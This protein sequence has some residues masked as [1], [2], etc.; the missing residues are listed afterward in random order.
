MSLLTMNEAETCR[1]LVRPKLEVVGW[2]AVG[3]RHYR[4]QIPITAG[5]IVVTGGKPKRLKKKIPDFLLYF[6]RDILLAVVEAKSDNRPATDGLQQAKDYAETL[7]LK[8]AYSTNGKEIIEYDYFTHTE[9]VVPAFPSPTEVWQRYLIGM[10][11][12]GAVRDALLV[13][14]FYQPNK[15]PR[16][17][18]RIAIERA[19]RAIVGGQKRCLLTLATG[20]GKT[21]VAF[22]ICWKLW[23]ARW[24]ANADPVR[25][26]RIL[27]LADRSKLVDD[28]KD[29]D[30]APFGHARWK[31]SGEAVTGREMYFALY[32]SLAEYENRKGLYRD[33]PRDYF[34]LIVIDECHRG[35]AGDEGSWRE[36]LDYFHPAYQ[37]GM[38]ATPQRVENKDSYLYF[39]NPLYVYSL[40][41]GIEDGF[42]APYRV[43]RVVSTFDAAGWRPNN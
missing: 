25:K 26:P 28:P 18:Q 21:T 13:P 5:R 37:L 6:T 19:I 27:F 31:I 15:V 32:Q 43:H 22:Q 29:K 35:S 8:F 17:Y 23:S 9:A 2:E 7:G 10:G 1:T 33:Y 38:T 3:E 12:S 16:Y 30:F 40:K 20:T 42:L 4:E 39:G 41:Q 36:I 11:I 34:D 14:D 24:N